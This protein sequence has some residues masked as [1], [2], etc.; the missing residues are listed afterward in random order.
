MRFD[1]KE[2]VIMN[3]KNDIM[4]RG[5]RRNNVNE[6]LASMAQAD[7]GTSRL[8]HER[9]D[10]LSMHTLSAMQKSGIVANLPPISDSND[11]CK[12]C[13]KGKEHRQPFLQES[14]TRA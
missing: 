8:W 6:L 13:M 14:S 9:F 7:E 12:A 3:N 1:K 10:H 4:A 5:V 11:V 2:I